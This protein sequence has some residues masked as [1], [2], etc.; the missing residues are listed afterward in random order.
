MVGVGWS[1]PVK[2]LFFVLLGLLTVDFA[3]LLVSLR[4][5]VTDLCCFDFFSHILKTAVSWDFCC[6]GQVKKFSVREWESDGPTLF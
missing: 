5:F 3:C 2:T 1:H 4:R 6:F